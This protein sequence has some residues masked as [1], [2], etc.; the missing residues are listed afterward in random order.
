[1]VFYHAITSFPTTHS[2]PLR[3]P[4]NQCCD[5]PTNW[6]I[7]ELEVPTFYIEIIVKLFF[8]QHE[9]ELECP[10]GQCSP[11]HI[12]CSMNIFKARV[13]SIT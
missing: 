2:T 3:V 7:I 10:Q 12:G 8:S 13:A 5:H 11:S 4:K 1:M 9:V 6:K